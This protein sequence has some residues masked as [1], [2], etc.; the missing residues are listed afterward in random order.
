M[1]TARDLILLALKTCGAIGEGQTPSAENMQDGLKRLNWLLA[2]WNRKRWLVYNTVDFSVATTGAV[3]YSIGPVTV[4]HGTPSIV[5]DPR[6]AKLEAAYLRQIVPSQPQPIDFPLDIIT[7]REEYSR[8]PLKTL[9]TFAYSIFYEPH[10]PV[11]FLYPWPVPQA[12]LYE[13]HIIV[14]TVLQKFPNLDTEFAIPEEYEPALESTLAIRLA[15]TFTLP[16]TPEM[17]A[18]SKDALNVLRQA[19]NAIGVLT[20]PTALMRPGIYDPYSDQTR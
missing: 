16:V 11:G 4:E 19:N 15:P 8:I 14:T 18:S 10:Y 6:P 3:S 17:L 7:S 13:V 9:T 20:L 2:Q 12:N 1:T 5:V